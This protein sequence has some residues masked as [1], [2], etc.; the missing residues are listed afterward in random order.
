MSKIL[1][2]SLLDLL[3]MCVIRILAIFPWYFVSVFLKYDYIKQQI[4]TG[5]YYMPDSIS[6][7]KPGVVYLEPE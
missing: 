7:E 5:H 2:F 1:K 3:K 4:F 6:V